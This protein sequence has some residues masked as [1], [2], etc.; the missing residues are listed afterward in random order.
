V[1]WQRSRS[2]VDSLL[3]DERHAAGSAAASVS[4]SLADP[5]PLRQA[6]GMHRADVVL[7]SKLSPA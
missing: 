6:S 4:S 1:Q 5:G 3:E 2:S 7:C